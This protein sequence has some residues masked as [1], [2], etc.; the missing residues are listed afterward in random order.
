MPVKKFALTIIIAAAGAM[1]SPHAAHAMD[2]ATKA[3]AA[4]CQDP[5]TKPDD[6]IK[7]CTKVLESGKMGPKS[8]LAM[9]YCRGAFYTKTNDNRKADQDFAAATQAYEEDPDKANWPVNIIE[10]AASSYSFRAQ[11][12]KQGNDCVTAGSYYKKAAATSREV[13]ER[14]NYEKAAKDACK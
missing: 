4:T 2:D 13:S 7:A 3:A 9:H 11:I 8:T 5:N 1:L 10:L 6:G 14:A 12:A